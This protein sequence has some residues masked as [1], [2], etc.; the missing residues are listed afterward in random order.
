MAKERLYFIDNLKVGLI[1]LVVIH[2][3]GQAYGPTGGFW[4]FV[5]SVPGE[6]PWLGRFFGVNAA[7]FMGLFFMISGYF[8]YPSFQRKGFSQFIVDKLIRYGIPLLAVYLVMMPLVLYFYYR[9]YSGNPP[10]SYWSYFSGIYLGIGGQAPWFRPSIGWPESNWGFGHLWFVEHLLLYSLLFAMFH[11]LFK[12]AHSPIM[13]N[14]YR[15]VPI[16]FVFIS[17][18]SIIVRKNYPIDRWVDLAGFIT[19]EP[20]HLP[21]YASLLLTGILAWK[22]NLFNRFPAIFG[23]LLL[24]LGVA[25]ALLIY[26][27]PYLPEG[28]SHAIWN[29]FEIYESLLCVSLCFGLI[30]FFRDHLNGSNSLLKLLADNSYGAY[31]VHFPVV[32]ALQLAFDQLKVHLLFKFVLVSVCAVLASFAVSCLF[33]QLKGMRSV[34]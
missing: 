9:N 5:S 14:P 12:S 13:V 16:L 19:S 17:V 33:R 18:L 15:L 6:L 7:F 29:H 27:A 11:L 31:I 28:L 24:M 30:V 34:I 32:I 26:G 21:Q 4:P 3:V 10:I 8:F 2:H 23:K 25:M 1:L 22:S 20:A